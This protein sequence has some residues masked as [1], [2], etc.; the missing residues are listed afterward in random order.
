MRNHL[1]PSSFL[2]ASLLAFITLSL[3]TSA[4]TTATNEWTWM[5]GS[6]ILGGSGI[7]PAVYG[8]L[9]T[10]AAGNTPGS[11]ANAVTWTDSNGNLWLFSGT[12]Y[13]EYTNDLW[14][15]SPSTTEWTW[16]G[17]NSK[18][19]QPGIYGTLGTPS[20]GNLA[21]GRTGAVSWTDASG[22]LWVF[23][24]YGDDSTGS[25]GFLDDLWMFNSSS[26]EWTWMGGNSTVKCTYVYVG[27][28][29][30]IC[31][32]SGVYGAL[33]TPSMAN[34]PGGRQNAVSWIDSNGNLWLFGGSGLD[35]SGTLGQLNDL[36]EFR[37]S[38]LEWNWVSGSSSS[39]KP[40]VYG[41]IRTPSPG[42]TPGSRS[43]SISWTDTKGNLWLFGGYGADS[44]GAVGY[45]N[46]LWEF[47][48]STS[49]WAG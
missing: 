31:G 2:F 35:A 30:M 18:G 40:G 36:W 11:R 47:D 33:G 26:N 38:T 14:E 8:T 5:G 39:G 19:G 6:S 20:A 9:G 13:D 7:L 1:S 45:L 32:Q 23:G 22:H 28:E 10:P 16:K 29:E 25:A 48:T 4:Q 46:D 42:N 44:S 34:I 15:F 21:G 24:G 27:G 37:P 17:G 49:K 41:T 12:N 3:S 43:K